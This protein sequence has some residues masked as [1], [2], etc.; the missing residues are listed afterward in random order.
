MKK[1]TFLITVLAIIAV[2]SC[3]Q[4]SESKENNADSA[5]VT[6]VVNPNLKLQIIYFHATHRCPT[7]NSIEANIKQVLEEFFKAEMEKGTI[8]F[9]VLNAEDE[10]N[11]A[12]AEKYQATGAA[13]HLIK[14]E[15]GNKIDKDFTEFAFA[16]SRKQPDEFL[17]TMKD[18]IASYIFN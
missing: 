5:V 3:N 6:E 17:L 9:D 12:L 14:I 8:T 1:I 15:N 16:K 11:K 7:C 18:S 2:A 10:A 4:N 13:L